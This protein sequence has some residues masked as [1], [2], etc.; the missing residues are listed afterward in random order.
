MRLP[1]PFIRLPFAFDIE[2][3]RT[4]IAQFGPTEWRPHPQ[5]H[6]GNW[7]L[8]LVAVDGDVTNEGVAGPM[9]PTPHL[10]RCPYVRQVMSAL[11]V[12]LGRSRLMKLDARAEATAH[13]DINYYW[14]QRVRV[15]VPVETFPEVQFLCGDATTQMAA[16]ECW[17]FDTWRQHNVLNPTPRERIH[18]V[19]DTV[20]SEPFW[21]LADGV[22]RPPRSVPFAAGSDPEL[23]FEQVNIPIVMSPWELEAAWD[24]WIADSYEGSADAE[25]VDALVAAAAPIFLRWRSLWAR[26]GDSPAGWPEFAAA[27][28]EFERRTHAPATTVGLPNG[29]NLGHIIKRSL[30]PAMHTP[31]QRKGSPRSAAHIPDLGQIGAAASSPTPAPTAASPRFDRPLIILAAPRSG[32]SLLFETL[33]QSPDLYS[34]GKESHRQ[35][36]SLAALRPE[37]RGH[38]SNR[39]IAADAAPEIVARLKRLFI[40]ELRDRDGGSLPA[41]A[42]AF[43]L[44]EKTPKNALRVPFLN[45]VF[46]DALYVYLYRDP[47]ENLSSLI[48]GWQSGRFV[49]YPNLPGWSGLPW[50]YL[51]V[52]GWRE[53]SGASI[54]SI[55]A[56][57]WRTTQQILLDDLEALPP[58]RVFALAYRDFIAEPE[59]HAREICSFAGVRWDRALPPALPLSAHTVTPPAPEKW[60]RHE[61]ELAPQLA[62][63]EAIAERA[64]GVV[65]SSRMRHGGGGFV[66]KPS[67]RSQVL[68]AK[69]QPVPEP[70]ANG[71]DA[72]PTPLASVHTTN[73][74]QILRELN[75]SLLITTYQAGKLILVRD[76]GGTLNTHFVNFRKPMGLAVDRAR[77]FIG[78]ETGI[79]EFRN[80]PAASARLEPPNRHDAVY[81]LRNQ[82]VTGNIDIHEMAIVDGECWYV[83]TLFSCLCT[84]D[85]EHS[86]VPRWR[87]RFITGLAPEDRCHLN[88]LAVVG[89]KPKFLTALGETDTPRG[90]RANKKDGGILLDYASGE[91]IARGLSMP[92]SPRWH[93]DRLW[94]LESG[95]G[96][97]C[98]VDLDTGKLETVARVPGF[99]RGLDFLGPLAFIGLSQLRET[100]AFTDIPITEENA[101]RMSGVWIVNV[102]SGQTIG[103]LKFSNVVQEIFAVQTLPG[104]RY[105]AIVDDD[106]DLIKSTYVLPDAALKE[107]RFSAPVPD[108]AT[109]N[110]D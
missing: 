60:K 37:S 23:A 15:H 62:T 19:I 7:A 21:R 34:V 78:T 4:E 90:W 67:D 49:M 85:G 53:L 100:N 44:L 64:R 105:P 94:V 8:P 39:L 36:E 31:T 54:A 1:Q 77:F 96:S 59:R 9:R 32:S 17:I 110:A 29:V 61:A 76:D 89:G 99:T 82:H 71:P 103:F 40:E 42:K 69:G 55:V 97:L 16:G 45:A 2:R 68:P 51:L 3:L 87:P 98:T 25:T 50:S 63:L 47:E 26:Y 13:V 66:E 108:E 35:F 48:E 75:T 11:G 6:P 65:S 38:D 80:V 74:P 104:M 88:G 101:D 107:V 46:P 72:T 43:R 27:T 70:E 86:F 24:A 93:R 12:P 83:N 18:L 106:D 56:E 81:V 91:A 41:D 57:Q 102:Q 20:G 52:P 22:A 33:L 30:V 14:M 58:E 92:H 28:E 5:N 10:A 73:L 79:R 109:T 95:R 84:Q